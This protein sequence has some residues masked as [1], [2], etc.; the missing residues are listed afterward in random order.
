M[1]IVVTD[2]F[3]L[4]P[5]VVA[6]LRGLPATILPTPPKNHEELIRQVADAAIF[7]TRF[8]PVTAAV[9]DACPNLR[10]IVAPTAGYDWID[11]AH[12]AKRG[13]QVVHCPTHNSRAVAEHA[14]ALTLAVMR[15]LTE[16]AASVT[17]GDF[18]PRAFTGQEANGKMMAIIGYGR[19]GRTV[20]ALAEAFG[21]NVHGATSATSPT[22]LDSLLQQADIIML[23]L[24]LT[25]STQQILNAQRIASLK[26]SAVIVNVGRGGLIDELALYDAL[27]R[28]AI[29]G[30]GLDVF[31]DEP[32]NGGKVT[33]LTRKLASLPN[34]VVTPHIGG[35][36][37]ESLRRLGDEFYDV[38]SSC[39]QG[40]PINLVR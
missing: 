34:V 20:G 26:K 38:L 6:K 9:I 36:T 11:V 18:L 27:H 32:A 39:A 23:C 12:A 14:F 35:N 5:D 3:G 1:K 31:H 16:A 17:H 24:P 22:E 8:I 15:R 40:K 28:G 19:I 10:Y 4:S 29:G 2:I 25:S 37:H 30:A 21:L 33:P 13:V 7:T